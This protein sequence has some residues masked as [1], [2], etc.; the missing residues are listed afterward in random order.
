M[1][2][3]EKINEALEPLGIPY[4][5]IERSTIVPPCIIYNYTETPTR[6]A[7]DRRNGMEYNVLLNVYTNSEINKNKENVRNSMDMCGFIRK[8]S[9]GALKDDT[10]FYN[11]PLSFFIDL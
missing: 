9:P 3:T 8:P 11:T 2:I 4:Y 5:Y 6:F 10:G 1:T 7:D